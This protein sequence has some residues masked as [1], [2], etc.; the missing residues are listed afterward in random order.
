MRGSRGR[1]AVD[2]GGLAKYTHL[3]SS[4]KGCFARRSAVTHPENDTPSL[5]NATKRRALARTASSVCPHCEI[6]VG[7]CYD[8]IQYEARERQET[9]GL[10]SLSVAPTQAFIKSSKRHGKHNR[11]AESGLYV[12][13]TVPS[14]PTLVLHKAPNEMRSKVTSP[15]LP[16]PPPRQNSV[17]PAL[18][19]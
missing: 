3:V 10:L 7:F 16:N 15:L 19:G 12:R 6:H 2:G 14:F 1:G 18:P 17:S 4:R 9:L 13:G 11:Y 8:A 5:R